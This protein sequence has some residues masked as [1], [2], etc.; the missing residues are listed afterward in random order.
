[1]HLQRVKKPRNQANSIL[2]I[3]NGRHESNIDL[4]PFFF[5]QDMEKY[6]IAGLG[7]IGDEYANTR[8]N[9][10]FIVLDALAQELKV[11]MTLQRHAFMCEARLKG[12]KL[13]LIKP[14]TYMNLSGKA[15]RYW[16]DKENISI[17]NLLVVVDDID[18]DTGVL[19]LRPKGSGGSHNGMNH[20]IE[21]LDN[22]EFARLRVGIGNDF[23]KGFQVDY[24]LGKWTSAEEKIMLE[25]IPLAVEMIKSFV[26]SGAQ[27]TMNNYNKR[28]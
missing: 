5:L 26:L 11:E 21:T 4:V 8:H 17:E 23:A 18:L 19:R 9:I 14:T 6:L 15:V 1:M 25:K 3:Y 20:I 2:M 12:R 16:L 27:F 28:K 13:I 10:G 24:V 22:N 7:N